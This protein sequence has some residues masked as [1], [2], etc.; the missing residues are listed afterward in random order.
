MW[1]GDFDAALTATAAFAVSS[2]RDGPAMPS[3]TIPKAKH[4][5][6]RMRFM[7]DGCEDEWN[8]RR[9][10]NT[11]RLFTMKGSGAGPQRCARPQ[12]LGRQTAD[13]EHHPSVAPLP[14]GGAARPPPPGA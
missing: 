6:D 9:D 11:F 2:A 3:A 4:T 1:S 10:Y 5:M 14:P 13:A 8:E 7:I 12:A